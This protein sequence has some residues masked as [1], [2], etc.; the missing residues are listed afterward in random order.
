MLT[1]K[2][3]FWLDVGTVHVSVE[4]NDG[5]GQDE[6]GVRIVKLLH[7]VRVTHAVALTVDV[8]ETEREEG[9]KSEKTWQKK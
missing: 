2:Q 6:D 8:E 4:Q 1:K 5:E 3:V 7:H 9:Q